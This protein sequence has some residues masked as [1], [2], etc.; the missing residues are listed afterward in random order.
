MVDLGGDESIKEGIG[1]EG[2]LELVMVGKENGL[3][4]MVWVWDND[5]V[6]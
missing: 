3:V 2:D 1:C 6:V 5:V 4:V